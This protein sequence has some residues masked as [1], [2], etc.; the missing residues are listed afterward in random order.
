M[1][2]RLGIV[3]DLHADLEA[4]RA[5][6]DH[7]DKLGV[8]QVVCAGDVVDGGDQPED[9]IALLRDRGIPTVQGNHDRWVLRRH[10]N[11]EP[12]HDGDARKLHLSPGAISWLAGLL[13]TWRKTIE[14]VRVVV[15]HGTPLSDMAGVYPETGSSE[16]ERTLERA[17]ADVLVCGHTHVPLAKHVSGGR[18]VINAGA[19]WRGAG[20]DPQA[21]LLDPGG[22]PSRASE[23][24]QGGT[25]GVLELPSKRW[26]LHKL[27]MLPPSAPLRD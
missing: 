18:L 24:P 25:F 21:M 26:T 23:Q 13:K 6:L 12:E 27:S 14:G 8:A 3:T 9:V 19:L 15:V 20:A 16:L 11:G 1:A 2:F 22:G 4:L 5:A 7:F 10:D 17:E